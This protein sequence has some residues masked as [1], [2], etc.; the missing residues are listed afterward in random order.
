MTVS[1]SHDIS[2]N[3][4]SSQPEDTPDMEYET[5]THTHTH[6]VS[7]LPF[8]IRTHACAQLH[9]IPPPRRHPPTRSFT[10]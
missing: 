5:H 7:V 1:M 10:H 3:D 6:T 4:Y 9:M 2:H 8:L